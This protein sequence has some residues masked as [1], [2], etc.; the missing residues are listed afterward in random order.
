MAAPFKVSI[1]GGSVGGLAAAIELRDQCGADVSVFERSAGEMQAR[2][3]G[4][5]MQP[6]VDALL[7]RIGIK[8]RD[9]CVELRERVGLALD[10]RSSVNHAPQL[11]TAWDTLYKRLR[12]HLGEACY[13][14]DS[15][16]IGLDQTDGVVTA[17]FADNHIAHPTF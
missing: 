2:G 11:M 15:R 5:V 10:G 1:I 3:A 8:T 13:R 14:P 7:N 4:V 9:V 17:T 6:E 12:S 16:L